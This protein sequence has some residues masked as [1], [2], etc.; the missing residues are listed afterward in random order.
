M[1]VVT[2]YPPGLSAPGDRTRCANCGILRWQ[3][4]GSRVVGGVHVCDAAIMLWFTA[5]PDNPDLSVMAL[6]EAQR[7]AV[8]A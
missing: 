6:A 3:T 1:E 4:A 8:A 2:R 5:D 7:A